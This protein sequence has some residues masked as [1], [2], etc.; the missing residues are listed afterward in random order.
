MPEQ[1]D[2]GDPTP[3][4]FLPSSDAV[5]QSTAPPG[6]DAAAPTPTPP[7]VTQLPN[8]GAALGTAP[9]TPFVLMLLTTLLLLLAALR[10]RTR[11]RA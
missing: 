1:P 11:D 6:R 9:R 8:A 7:L 4:P 10:L 5:A 2:T 3:T